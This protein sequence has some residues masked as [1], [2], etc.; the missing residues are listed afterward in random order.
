MKNFLRIG[1]M[2]ILL[3]LSIADILHAELRKVA[4]IKTSP[5][6]KSVS[7]APN[8]KTAY[9]LNLEGMSI[10]AFDIAS[11]RLRWKAEFFPTQSFG[12]DYTRKKT[13]PS[14]GEKPVEAAFTDNGRYIWVSLHNDTSV[15]VIDTEWQTKLTGSEEMK[16]MK[17]YKNDSK[18]FE[19]VFVKRLKVGKT[20]KVITVSPDESLVYVANWHSNSISVISAQSLKVIHEITGLTVPRGMVCSGDGNYLFV[21]NMS[22][23]LLTK[24][25]T[26]SYRIIESF[27]VGQGPRHLVRADNI[28]LMSL[29]SAGE[30]VTFGIK[31]GQILARTKVGSQPR[32]IV[33]SKDKKLLFGVLYNEKKVFEINTSTLDLVQK[34]PTGDA[35]VGLDITP[36]G[37]E[38]WVVN[39]RSSTLDVFAITP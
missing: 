3:V 9:V 28:L 21:A 2:C 26:R 31:E 11:K 35:P 7:I 33:L 34:Y 30:V 29:N 36:D 23:T 18:G 20:P 14:T 19:T 25:D 1:C 24:I 39:Y 15:V 10:E 38:L 22:S 32:T 5:A 16:K 4:T 6:P 8:G 27:E 37:K 17:L 13:I 12:W